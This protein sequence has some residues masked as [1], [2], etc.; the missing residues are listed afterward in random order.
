MI[1]EFWVLRLPEVVKENKA[2]STN[3]FE[4][5]S[6]KEIPLRYMLKGLR[7]KI[8]NIHR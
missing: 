2:N 4:I 8:V 3:P 5:S 6:K 7:R 1:S